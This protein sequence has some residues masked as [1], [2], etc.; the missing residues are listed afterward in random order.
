MLSVRLLSVY[1]CDCAGARCILGGSYLPGINIIFY[2]T[3]RVTDEM[4]ML[5]SVKP[6]FNHFCHLTA[7]SD[8]VFLVVVAVI[9]DP[10][11]V[12]ADYSVCAVSETMLSCLPLY[13]QQRSAA[14]HPFRYNSSSGMTSINEAKAVM[15][16]SGAITLK[17]IRAAG[18]QAYSV[19]P[20]FCRYAAA[21]ER[22]HCV[23]C[24]CC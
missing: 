24:S 19:P 15:E 20:V 10:T 3:D 16:E 5:P 4:N 18:G 14:C 23:S 1:Y 6:S 12:F 8:G 7:P 13:F 9:I 11:T 17:H 21:A 22:G 2:T